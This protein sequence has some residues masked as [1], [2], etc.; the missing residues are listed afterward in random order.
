MEAKKLDI[1]KTKEFIDKYWDESLQPA[2]EEFVRIPNL[3]R[4]Y[5]ENWQTNGRLEQ[6]AQHVIDWALKQNIKG[7]K[8]KLLK[9]EGKTPMVYMDI[10]GTNGGKHPI[11]MYAHL[12]K[13]P[14]FDG[15]REEEGIHPTKP[16]RKGDF[17]FG[18]GANDDGYGSFAALTA[19]KILQDQNLPYPRTILLLETDEESGSN[20]Y[21]YYLDKV[22]GDFPDIAVVYCLDSGCLTYDSLWIT[23]SLRGCLIVKFTVSVLKE[24]VHS[25]D[26]SGVV[27]SSFRI[28]RMLLDRIEDSKTGTVHED[29]H[30]VIPPN[31]YQEAVKAC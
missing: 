22:K 17:L 15:W 5:D 7:M 28:I 27:P 24:G 2:I 30:V 13:Q 19:I 8:V 16:I 26:A 18:R 20:D 25:G 6:A 9:D 21:K 3:S 10:E 11:L 31:R 1:K 4:D 29:L 12:D 23:G 14:Y